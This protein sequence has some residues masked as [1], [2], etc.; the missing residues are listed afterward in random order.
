MDTECKATIATS[1]CTRVVRVMD[2]AYDMAKADV[3]PDECYVDGL[4]EW[5]LSLVLS[6]AIAEVGRIVTEGML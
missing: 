5:A 2:C 1:M 4:M 6:D 3:V